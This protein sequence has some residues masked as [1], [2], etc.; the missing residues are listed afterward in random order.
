M[1]KIIVFFTMFLISF[2]FIPVETKTF[3]VVFVTIP[4]VKVS[5]IVNL[6][7]FDIS[8]LFKLLQFAKA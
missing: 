4:L 8:I 1:K 2:A 3:P 6:F 5:V 7:N